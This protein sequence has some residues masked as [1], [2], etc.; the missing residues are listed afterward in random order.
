MSLNSDYMK[1]DII[2][3]VPKL[4]K[5]KNNIN[6]NNDINIDLNSYVLNYAGELINLK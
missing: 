6:D 4:K 3:N 2:E 5:E 1:V